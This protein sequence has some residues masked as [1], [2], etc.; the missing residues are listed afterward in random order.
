MLDMNLQIQIDVLRRDVGQIKA[1]LLD[2]D[3][4]VPDRARLAAVC[5]QF[6]I[7]TNALKGYARSSRVVIAR[8]AVIRELHSKF[9]WN[10]EKLC[11]VASRSKRHVLRVISR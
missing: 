10:L 1:M 3:Q 11:H 7:T 6:G 2:K 8:K 5:H 9:G 4:I